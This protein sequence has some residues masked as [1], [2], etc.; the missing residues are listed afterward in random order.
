MALIEKCQ[1]QLRFTL[2]PGEYYIDLASELSKVN[3]KHFSQG[4]VYGIESIQMHFAQ[5]K[6]YDTLGTEIVKLDVWTAGDTWAVHNAWTK[7]KALYD[8]MQQLVLSDNP[9]VKGTWADFRVAL[10]TTMADRILSGTYGYP[11]LDVMDGGGP[12][13]SPPGTLQRVEEGQ[14]QYSQYV[15]PEHVVDTLSGQPIPA[16]ECFS[17]LIGADLMEALDPTRYRSAGLVEAYAKSR[18]TVQPEDPQV[19]VG[20][21]DSFFNK[22]TDSGSQEPELAADI[23]AFGDQPPYFREYYPGGQTNAPTP[24]KIGTA[25]ANINA[26]SGGI[27]SFVAQCGLLKLV[28]TSFGADLPSTQMNMEL[29]ITLMPGDYKGVAAI[30]MGQ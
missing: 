4:M 1:R 26:P 9:S 30:P 7:G 19:P 5:N 15:L 21:E 6:I 28:N 14:W 10:N 29:I 23:I 17:H 3:R 20:F 16:D 25:V 11:T 24:W 18:A 12:T 8:E 27:G 22:L 13:T 2:L